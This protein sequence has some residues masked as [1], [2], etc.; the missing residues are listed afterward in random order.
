V[1]AI[2]VL[3]SLASLV[4][5]TASS[6]N[7]PRPLTAWPS[8]AFAGSR[9]SLIGFGKWRGQPVKIAHRFAAGRTWSD[10]E[11]STL[12]SNFGY[13]RQT[14]IS[15]PMLPRGDA[16][17]SLK[18]GASGG[19]NAHWL[20][21]GERLVAEGMG[22]AIV[23]PGWEFNQKWPRWAARSDPSGYAGYFRQIVDTMRSIP[24]EAF[25]FEWSP[26]ASYQ[27]WDPRTA[28]PGNAYVDMIGL[29]Q[30]DLWYNH[31]A[32]TPWQRWNFIVNSNGPAAEGGLRFW[33]TFAQD[34]G[35]PIALSEWGLTNKYAPMAGPHGGGGGDDPF[36]IRQ[37]H[38]W[39]A[40][41]GIAYEAY[42]DSNAPDGHH[43]L[44]DNEFPKAAGVYRALW[45]SQH[46]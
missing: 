31:P 18:V 4:G 13:R 20:I 33:A 17:A 37:M 12:S 9:K 23:R 29:D 5:V 6:R 30:Y 3:C 27:G 19:Y 40:S 36:Y 14:V 25:R 38:H 43:K 21:A 11:L 46:R 28:Y 32:A 34:L 39:L 15:I 45:G 26:S 44:D 22:N 7:D 16:G 41:H 35:E 10:L 2:A 24:G 42:L 1:K 8:G